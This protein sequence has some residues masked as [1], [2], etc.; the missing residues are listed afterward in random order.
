MEVKRVFV[1]RAINPLKKDPPKICEQS[2]TIVFDTFKT[3]LYLFYD[4]RPE[5]LKWVEEVLPTL[6]PPPNPPDAGL[7]FYKQMKDQYL[8]FDYGTNTLSL[9][10]IKKTTP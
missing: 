7:T 5:A 8:E 4:T 3:K 2:K 1:A 6:L 9:C 10:F